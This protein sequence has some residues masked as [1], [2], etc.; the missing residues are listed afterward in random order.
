MTKGNTFKLA[1]ELEF[2]LHF[3]SRIDLDKSTDKEVKL[4]DTWK[5]TYEQIWNCHV[6]LMT[7]LKKQVYIIILVLMKQFLIETC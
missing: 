1:Q 5:T 6:N 3:R 7:F 2:N 4:T